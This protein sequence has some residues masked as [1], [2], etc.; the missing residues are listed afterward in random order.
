METEEKLN[1]AI[2]KLTMIIQEQY[3]ELSKYIAEMPVTI[4][5]ASIPKINI[6]ALQE[7]YDSLEILLNDYAI[8]HSKTST[9]TE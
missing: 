1:A 8:N 2:L 9:K 6:K 5:N 3:P 7:Y 4:P